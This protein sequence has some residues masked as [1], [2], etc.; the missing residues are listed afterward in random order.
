M[1]EREADIKRESDKRKCPQI[2]VLVKTKT[3]HPLHKS[4]IIFYQK[5]TFLK[6]INWP[7]LEDS[8]P[9]I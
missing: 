9:L 2:V 4:K 7:F 3:F 8:Q 1:R 5:N 6:Q